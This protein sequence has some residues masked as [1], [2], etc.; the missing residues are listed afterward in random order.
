M[1]LI[2]LIYSVF[3]YVLTSILTFELAHIRYASVVGST[4]IIGTISN[5]SNVRIYP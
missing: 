1:D 3:S 2:V 4:P 5:S